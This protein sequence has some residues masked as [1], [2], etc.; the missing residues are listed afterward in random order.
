MVG[1]RNNKKIKELNKRLKDY[2]KENGIVYI[3]LYET[4]A[5][6]EGNIKLEYTKEGL[7]LSDKGYEA[8]TKI[9]KSYLK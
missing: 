4:L 2:C 6:S 1:D 7:H 5:D 8:V 3:N 9:I